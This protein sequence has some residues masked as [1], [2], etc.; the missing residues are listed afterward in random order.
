M[1]EVYLRSIEPLIASG[2]IRTHQKKDRDNQQLAECESFMTTQISRRGKQYLETAHTLL[3]AAK[4]MDD[5]S[6]ARQLK[7]LADDYRRR[8][9]EA[10]HADAAKAL[11]KAGARLT[12]AVE[13]V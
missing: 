8:G 1:L 12:A 10:S 13:M 2:L 9:V 3:R 11:A 6:V 7:V 4:T 5:Q